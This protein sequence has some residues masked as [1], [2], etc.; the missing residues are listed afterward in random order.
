MLTRPEQTETEH[1]ANTPE[2]A[3]AKPASLNWEDPFLLDEQ[4]TD[5]ERMIRDSAYAYAQESLQP[6][7]L[8]ANRHERFDV[9]IV[10]RF[11]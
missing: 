6:R 8:E 7:I 4:L 1:H 9:E 5:D 3:R 11:I 10:C 2:L